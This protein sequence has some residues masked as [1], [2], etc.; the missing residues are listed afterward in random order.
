MSTVFQ[1]N[2]FQQICAP[3]TPQISLSYFCLKRSRCTLE[4]MRIDN[5]IKRDDKLWIDFKK[6][7]FILLNTNE[8][9]RRMNSG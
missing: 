5:G 8:L 3:Q 1:R 2:P 4:I 6:I 9:K 7:N